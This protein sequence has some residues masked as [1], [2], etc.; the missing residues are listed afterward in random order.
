[1]K[2][3]VK[4]LIGTIVIFASIFSVLQNKKN[5][6]A[7]NTSLLLDNVEALASGEIEFPALCMA[8]PNY[9]CVRFADG[10]VIFGIR[11]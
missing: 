8:N 1:M 5:V 7:T 3:I 4:V 11:Y 10:Y 2:K 9:L 6:P